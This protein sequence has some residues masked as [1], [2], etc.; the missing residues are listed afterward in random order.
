[1]Y[2]RPMAAPRKHVRSF[3]DPDEVISV[4]P[5]RSVDPT[6]AARRLGDRAWAGLLGT[7]ESA[8]RDLLLSYRDREVAGTEIS[9]GDR[10]DHELRGFEG[11]R[12]L[13]VVG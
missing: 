12:R 3:S 8:T 1:M 6:G 5:L 2:R 9:L 4:G 10:G 7:P 13:H 11:P